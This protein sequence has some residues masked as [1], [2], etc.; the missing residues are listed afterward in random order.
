MKVVVNKCYGGFSVSRAAILWM[1]ERGS[2]AAKKNVLE[3]EKYPEGSVREHGMLDSNYIECERHDP[4]LVECVETLGRESYGQL[5][6]L[7]VIKIPDDIEYE[8]D[9]YDGIETIHEKHRSW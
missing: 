1:R 3:G 2:E 4:M 6:A 8:I 5:S 9:D 7:V